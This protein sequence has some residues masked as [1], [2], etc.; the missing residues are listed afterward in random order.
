MEEKAKL[1]DLGRKE[2]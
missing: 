2:A 1:M